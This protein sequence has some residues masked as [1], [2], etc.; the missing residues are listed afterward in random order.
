MRVRAI[1]AGVRRRLLSDA[2]VL[3]P[4]GPGEVGVFASVDGHD[5]G[6]PR[7]RHAAAAMAT[8]PPCPIPRRHTATVGPVPSGDS[9]QPL[10][11]RNQYEV[12]APT[13][14]VAEVVVRRDSV[15]PHQATYRSGFNIM[16][17]TGGSTLIVPV[18]EPSARTQHQTRP[19][20]RPSGSRG[21]GP[22]PTSRDAASDTARRE[23]V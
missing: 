16:R 9:Q 5:A 22:R 17:P 10:G 23:Q 12:F 2:G 21:Y 7:V 8:R 15:T 19:Q 4:D 18:Q 6:V 3:V 20:R 14:A 11:W 1:D 13:G